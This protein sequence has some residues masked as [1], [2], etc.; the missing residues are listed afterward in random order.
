LDEI[1][2]LL[3]EEI[4]EMISMQGLARELYVDDSTVRNW[5][6]TRKITPGPDFE[7]SMGNVTY[8]YFEKSRVDTIREQ[9]GIE[10]RNPGQMKEIF[11]EYVKDGTMSASL[12]PVMLKG[13]LTLADSK[14]QVDLMELT[15][16]FRKF[17]EDRADQGLAIEVRG[18]VVN[19]IIEMDDYQ[20]ANYMLKMPF[21][22]FERKYFV[23]HKK[24]LNKVAF[25]PNIWRKLSE[26]EKEH[27]INIC[28]KQIRDYYE[29][30]VD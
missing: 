20:L 28:D 19:R 14:G 18:A 12:K 2:S 11:M 29:R 7:V 3:R 17:Y 16:Y 26:A 23:E 22:K 5:I 21:E 13:M 4:K 30:R 15:R 1:I 27:L 24:E 25:S 10:K 8:K 6:N 9:L